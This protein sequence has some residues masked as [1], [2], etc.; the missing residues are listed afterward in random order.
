MKVEIIRSRGL[1]QMGRLAFLAVCCLGIWWPGH[2]VQA[3]MQF[4]PSLDDATFE[5]YQGLQLVSRIH[6]TRVYM[7]H[8]RW[9]FF[10]IGLIPVQVVEGVNLQIHSADSL[11]N[12][13]DA[14]NSANLSSAAQRHLEFR[15][16]QISL[17]DEKEPRLRAD[18]AS[19]IQPGVLQ[20]SHVSVSNGGEAISIPRAT[21]Q[22]GGPDCGCLRWNEG[23]SQN[24]LFVF[25]TSKN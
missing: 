18:T 4:S 24:Q 17:L 21:L 8:E 7:D 5:K 9:G 12:A 6:I 23:G 19:I 1:Y 13:M 3:Q 10:K 14:I 16:I 25:Q 2:T 22:A 20:L 15:N 11:T